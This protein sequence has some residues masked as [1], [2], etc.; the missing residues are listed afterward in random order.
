[1]FI[2]MLQMLKYHPEERLTIDEIKHHPFFARTDWLNMI[3]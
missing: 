1:M 3:S 2:K